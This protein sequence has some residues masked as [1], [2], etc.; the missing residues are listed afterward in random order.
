MTSVVEKYYSPRELVFLV[1]FTARHWVGKAEAGELAGATQL[2]GE[3]RIPGS[4]V[5][6]LLQAGMVRSPEELGVSARS[7]GELR[8]KVGLQRGRKAL[9]TSGEGG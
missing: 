6:A 3:W 2:F 9:Q 7:E 5:N 8:R 1:G 4:T